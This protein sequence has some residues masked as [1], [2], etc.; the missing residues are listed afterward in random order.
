MS[1]IMKMKSPKFGLKEPGHCREIGKVAKDLQRE[2]E[3]TNYSP[4]PLSLAY[5][6][7]F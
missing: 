6:L 5:K 4:T 1:G 2:S 3:W 7:L